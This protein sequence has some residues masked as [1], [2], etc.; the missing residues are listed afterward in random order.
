MKAAFVKVAQAEDR[1]LSN[2]LE[3]MIKKEIERFSKEH[4]DPGYLILDFLKSLS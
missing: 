2:K 3:R 4:P 1:G